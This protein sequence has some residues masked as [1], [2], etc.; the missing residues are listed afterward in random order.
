MITES[1][2]KRL[3]EPCYPYCSVSMTGGVDGDCDG[4]C[5][6]GGAACDGDCTG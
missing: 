2:L 5:G 3:K 6:S 4:Q 1:V